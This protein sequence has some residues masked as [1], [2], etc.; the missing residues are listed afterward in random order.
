MPEELCRDPPPGARAPIC[1]G[2]AASQRRHISGSHSLCTDTGD[3]GKKEGE[4]KREKGR[5]K[6]KSKGEIEKKTCMLKRF[7]D[8]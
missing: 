2:F 7:L 3:C 5:E 4:A 1:G 8:I 6:G